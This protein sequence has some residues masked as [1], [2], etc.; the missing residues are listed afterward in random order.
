MADSKQAMVV[1]TI[2]APDLDTNESGAE[3]WSVQSQALPAACKG[4]C[5]LL[6]FGAFESVLGGGGQHLVIPIADDTGDWR[7][8]VLERILAVDSRILPLAGP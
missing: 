3:A 2:E 5:F 4:K 1:T 6:Q 8:A 7:Q